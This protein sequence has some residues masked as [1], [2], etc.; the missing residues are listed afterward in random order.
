MNVFF[1]SPKNSMFHSVVERWKHLCDFMCVCLKTYSH[2][3]YEED[4][5]QSAP[6]VFFKNMGPSSPPYFVPTDM[7]HLHAF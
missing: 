2:G 4:D 5:C 7:L 1:F 3:M 6:V